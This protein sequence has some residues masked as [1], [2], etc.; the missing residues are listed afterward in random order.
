MVTSLRVFKKQAMRV[1]SLLVPTYN[2]L[3]CLLGRIANFCFLC[4]ATIFSRGSCYLPSKGKIRLMSVCWM[5]QYKKYFNI[6]CKCM[7][8]SHPGFHVPFLGILQRKKQGDGCSLMKISSKFNNLFVLIM[9]DNKF[10]AILGLA[11]PTTNS[12]GPC[13]QTWG[14]HK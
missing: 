9:C 1:I 11:F 4:V 5:K 7:Y 13:L 6:L 3:N 14:F 12:F 10:K 2:V 8:N